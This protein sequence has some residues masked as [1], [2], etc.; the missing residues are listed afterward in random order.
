MVIQY[1]DHLR[2]LERNKLKRADKRN[3]L[4]LEEKQK[5]FED[6]NWEAIYREGKLVKLKV[7]VLDL[8]IAKRKLKHSKGTLKREKVDI[9]TADIVTLLY[10]NSR[11]DASDDDI[12]E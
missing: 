11:G 10:S 7:A 9:V 2:E 5:G 3:R 6:Y 4:N 12:D 8:Y 1:L